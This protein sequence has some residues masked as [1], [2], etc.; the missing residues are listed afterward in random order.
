MARK[1]QF[2]AIDQ[3]GQTYHGLNHPR[4]DLLSQLGRRHATKMYID[5]KDGK[6]FHV[7]YVIGGLW[8]TLY[9]VAPFER[10]R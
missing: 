7:G 4:K 8:L 9:S 2:M 1:P 10:A 3:Y 6:T 5:H